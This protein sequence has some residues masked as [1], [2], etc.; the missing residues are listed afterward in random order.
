MFL[1]SRLCF[2]CIIVSG[3]SALSAYMRIL[4]VYIL[5]LASTFFFFFCLFGWLKVIFV[6]LVW[7]TA[8]FHT[9]IE[10]RGRLRSSFDAG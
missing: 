9:K 10:G 4:T 1:C 8:L 5:Q 3:F 2:I 6:V 7:I